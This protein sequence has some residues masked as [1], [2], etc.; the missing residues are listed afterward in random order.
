VGGTVSWSWHWPCCIVL[1]SGGDGFP[2][3]SWRN[4]AGAWFP[5]AWW[6]GSA[7]SEHKM[8]V[9]TCES[10]CA[11]EGASSEAEPAR[12]GASPRA[13]RR[14]A[15]ERGGA[16]S[17][18]VLALERDGTCSRE[19]L[20]LERG[21]TYSRGPLTGPLRWAAGATAAWVMPCVCV[22]SKRCV[23]F[24]YLRVLSRIRPVF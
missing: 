16:R 15:L 7:V 21:E 24:C 18:E 2:L 17:R 12:G 9:P 4:S 13:R 1:Q 23:C 11:C 22:L 10:R 14:W 5:G 3:G 8:T 6:R 19:A 20:A